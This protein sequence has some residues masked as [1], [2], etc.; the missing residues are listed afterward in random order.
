MAHPPSESANGRTNPASSRNLKPPAL[1]GGVFTCHERTKRR[2]CCQFAAL[3]RS[4]RL[5]HFDGAGESELMKR[6]SVRSE[7][8]GL[9]PRTQTA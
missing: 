9:L 7:T 5:I 3:H 2:R 8:G 6:R 1:A 4:G